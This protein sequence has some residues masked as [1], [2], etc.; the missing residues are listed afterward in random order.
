[1]IALI[2]QA[3]ELQAFLNDRGWRFCFI[4]GLAVIRW[5]EPRLTRD[6]DVSL[7][8]GFGVEEDFAKPLIDAFTPRIGDA[9]Q[10]A[11]VNRV[12]LLQGSDQVGIDIALAGLPFEEAMI[13][14]ATEFEYLPGARLRTVSAEDL[15]VLKAFANRPLDWHDVTGIA[16]RQPKLD[17]PAIFERL[18]PLV[19][20]KE[21]PEI[22]DR[23][24]RVHSGR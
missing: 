18:R 8:T 7:F 22:L 19:E 4:G 13:G 11:R 12:L 6:I 9:L 15:I 17:W 3:V 21:E 20:L 16:A 14:R 23:L 5:G 1:V 10:F 2:E 24:D